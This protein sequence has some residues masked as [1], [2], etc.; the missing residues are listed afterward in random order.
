MMIIRLIALVF[1]LVVA[2]FALRRLG[3]G[4]AEMGKKANHVE[5]FRYA[6]VLDEPGTPPSPVRPK[7]AAVAHLPRTASS[8]RDAAVRAMS[9]QDAAACLAGAKPEAPCL[10]ALAERDRPAANAAAKALVDKPD[11]LGV[12]ARSLLAYAD[13]AA[14]IAALTGSG[15]E[16][17]PP[18]GSVLTLL[19]LVEGSPCAL[20]FDPESGRLPNRHGELLTTLASLA[21]RELMG[22][23]EVVFDESEP[24]NG[25]APYALRAWSNDRRFTAQARNFDGWYDVDAV[26]GLLNELARRL[27][28]SQR[29]ILVHM[30]GHDA[31]VVSANGPWLQDVVTR[32]LLPS[33][34]GNERVEKAVGLEHV[35]VER[36]EAG[37][38]QAR[39]SP[40]SENEGPALAPRTSIR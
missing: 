40:E 20:G 14:L 9:A 37:L 32:G 17:E 39:T 5:A 22:P 6:P 23:P 31:L 34:S 28:K 2:V 21:A 4:F 30:S 7:G 10:R 13:R 18:S 36:H 11:A 33:E 8:V 25:A 16:R 3:D 29:W 12:L 26:L 35:I 19:D 27:G 15:C 24:P 38:K 1:M